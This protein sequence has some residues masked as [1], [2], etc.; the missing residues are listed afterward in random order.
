MTN[1]SKPIIWHV[2]G[3]FPDPVNFAKTSVIR[4][5]VDLTRE[6]FDHHVISINRQSPNLASGIVGG[7]GGHKRF[8]SSLSLIDFD[9]GQAVAYQAPRM[10]IWHR[11]ILGKLGDVLATQIKKAQRKPDL[12]IGHKLTIEGLIVARAAKLARV[13]YGITLQG[14][15]DRKILKVRPDLFRAFRSTFHGARQI[16]AF[17]P[18]AAQDLQ[19][20]LG[21]HP[22]LSLIPCP[23]ELDSPLVP[24]IRGNGFL[25]LFHLRN[26]RVK[27]LGRLAKAMTL[28]QDLGVKLAVVGGGSEQDR[29][30]CLSI[31]RSSPGIEFEGPLGREQVLR[32]M[33]AATAFVMPSLSETFGLVF[34]EA[35]FAGL[36]IIYPADRAIDGYFDDLPF[37]LRVDPKSPRAISEA[38]QYAHANEVALKAELARW[39]NTQAMDFFA[40]RSIKSL[41]SK[42]IQS[43]VN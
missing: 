36:P 17:A 15:T 19:A 29:K 5:L 1:S 38:L 27:N 32:R 40:R 25:T 31:V 12:L 39:Q 23:T 9:Y 28:I 7:L 2:S 4:S 11:T 34:V 10:G 42:A 3:D 21:A 33:N 14:N 18:N 24:S 16:T 37:A 20:K 22:N 41:F 35:L 8:D 26:H 6:E 13:P 30:E 43:A